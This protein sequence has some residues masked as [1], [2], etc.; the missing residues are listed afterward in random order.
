MDPWGQLKLFERRSK[1][2]PRWP[3]ITIQKSGNLGLNAAAIA[4]L[5][6]TGFVQFFYSDNPP[7]LG[8][9][10]AREGEPNT[11]V[12]KAQAGGGSGVVTG[13]GV[14]GMIGLAYGDVARRFAAKPV[15]GGL[16]VDLSGQGEQVTPGPPRRDD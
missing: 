11:Y 4:A 1:P 15:D 9:R 6:G 10:A 7:T 13:K 3:T 5:G 8:I 16:I 14:V 2:A 12:I